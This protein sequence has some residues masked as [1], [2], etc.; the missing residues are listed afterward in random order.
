[1]KINKLQIGFDFDNV[2]F[3]KTIITPNISTINVAINTSSKKTEKKQ[4]NVKEDVDFDENV[5]STNLRDLY[6]KD[7]RD[8][9]NKLLTIEEEKEYFERISK[10]D[11][12]AK[13]EFVK[14]NLRL[15]ISIAKTYTSNTDSFSNL[16]IIQEGNIGLLKAVEKYNPSLGNKFSTFA[17]W[18]I[19]QAIKRSLEDKTRQIRIPNHRT[20]QINRINK[21]IQKYKNENYSE[22]SI[23]TISQELN[24]SEKSIEKAMSYNIGMTSIN[25]NFTEDKET[26]LG[27]ILSN[28]FNV[29][30]HV[31]NQ[32]DKKT[33]YESIKLLDDTEKEIIIL[34]YYNKYKISQIEKMLGISRNNINKTLKNALLKMKKSFKNKIV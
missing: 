21:F 4:V 15:V 17:V 11:K 29:E 14:L 18:W 7:I 3:C 27:D 32:E 19:H 1:M 9:D 2:D 26:E 28:G 22:P 24:C 13:D 8:V 5:V 16:D 25:I 31:I 20:Q 6:N 10:G 12:K 30:D 34:R 23:S 33:L